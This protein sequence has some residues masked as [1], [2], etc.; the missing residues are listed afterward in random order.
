M[1][2][3]RLVP[4]PLSLC[5]AVSAVPEAVLEHIGQSR[6]LVLLPGP[7]EVEQESWVRGL[8]EDGAGDE[9]GL[10]SG[11][12]AALV[13]RQTRLILVERAPRGELHSLP[14]SLRLLARSGG[15][16]AWRGDRSTPLSSSFWKKL[17]YYMPAQQSRK[18]RA[19]SM[20]A[21]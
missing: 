21:L 13:E 5:A 20:T 19:E 7:A 17:R 6:R 10:L 2:M 3:Y 4:T 15:A 14:E 18:H 11:L 8:V 1:C 9:Q 12:H 16:V